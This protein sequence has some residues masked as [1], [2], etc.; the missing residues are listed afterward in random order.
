MATCPTYSLSQVVDQFLI[1]KFDSKR[2]WYKEF[3]VISADVWKT[4]FWNTLFVTQQKWVPVQKGHPYPYVDIPEG[5]HIF[6][7]ASIEDKRKIS[8][9]GHFTHCD[10]LMDLV[11]N[12][13]INVIPQPI[14]STCGCGKGCTSLCGAIDQWTVTIKPVIINNVTYQEKTWLKYC[15]NGDVIQYREIPTKQYMSKVIAGDYNNDYN[16]DFSNGNQLENFKVIT[17]TDEKIICNLK[18][19][20]CGC[21]EDSEENNEKFDIHC[22]CHTPYWRGSCCGEVCYEFQEPINARNKGEYKFSN[23]GKRLYLRRLRRGTKWVLITYQTDGTVVDGEIQVPDYCRGVM[24]AGIENASKEY[25]D[26]FN[27]LE[28]QTANYKLIDEVNKLI[29]QMNR[30]SIVFLSNLQNAAIHW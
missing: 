23:D 1:R 28:K 6:V 19:K 4:L 12:T 11:Y 20:P 17:Y 8:I 10:T 2:K 13:S 22:G 14:H 29:V 15:P 7:K 3:L 24:F 25:N 16:N 18:P 26:R 21:P 27:R 5:C 30:L 9:N